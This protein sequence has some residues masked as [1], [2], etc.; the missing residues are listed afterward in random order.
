MTLANRLCSFFLV[1]VAL[2]LVGFSAVM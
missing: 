2:L 1:A